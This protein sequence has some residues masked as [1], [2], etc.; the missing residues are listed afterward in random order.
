MFSQGVSQEFTYI[1][2]GLHLHDAA[3]DVQVTDWF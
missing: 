1:G 2:G 3:G